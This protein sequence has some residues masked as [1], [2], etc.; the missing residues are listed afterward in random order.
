VRVV[1][2]IACALFF[3]I[4]SGIRSAFYKVTSNIG[5][6]PDMSGTVLKTTN[7]EHKRRSDKLCRV[8]AVG[9][10]MGVFSLSALSG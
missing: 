2:R 7:E 10:C 4:V 5:G 8:I 3:Y 9:I 1:A 6:A